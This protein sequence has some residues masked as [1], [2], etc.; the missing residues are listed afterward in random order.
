MRGRGSNSGPRA[1]PDPA[2]PLSRPTALRDVDLDAI[3]TR[4]YT[5]PGDQ[6]RGNGQAHEIAERAR[7]ALL[8]EVPHL[9]SAIIHADPC[10]HGGEDH[11][12]VLAHH[13]PGV[14][15]VAARPSATTASRAD[16]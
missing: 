10:G 3:G 14:S 16:R 13:G 9:A 6:V 12:A 5:G 15:A 8:H 1:G 7:H 2:A 11:H 4:E